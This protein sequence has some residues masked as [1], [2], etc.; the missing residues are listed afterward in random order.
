[1]H[2]D[3]AVAAALAAGL[4]HVRDAELDV[5]LEPALELVLGDDVAAVDLHGAAVHQLPGRLA[6]PP[7]FPAVE[8]L[9]VEEHDGPRGR[10][11]AAGAGYP[12]LIARSFSSNR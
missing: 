3:A 7:L 9:A 11:A 10:R 2:V 4:G 8:A 12:S 5:E 1:L 6:A